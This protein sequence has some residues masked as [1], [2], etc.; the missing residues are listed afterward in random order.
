MGETGIDW[1]MLLYVMQA[2]LVLETL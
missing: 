1:Q 2:E